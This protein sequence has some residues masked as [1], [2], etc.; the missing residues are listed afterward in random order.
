M[1]QL[2]PNLTARNPRRH[3]YAVIFDR[4]DGGGLGMFVGAYSIEEAVGI[5]RGFARLHADLISPEWP[6]VNVIRCDDYQTAMARQSAPILAAFVTA[7]AN[8]IDY[9]Y[10]P[11]DCSAGMKITS[12]I[13]ALVASLQGS[14][15]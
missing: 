13:P 3:I 11:L 1:V 6:P 9:L 12:D 10:K 7:A 2:V 15:A 8:N 5:A 4:P 14:P